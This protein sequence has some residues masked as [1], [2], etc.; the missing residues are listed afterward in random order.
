[1]KNIP[2]DGVHGP[3]LPYPTLPYLVLR[4]FGVYALHLHLHYSVRYLV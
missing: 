4:G 2:C 1:M 3:T